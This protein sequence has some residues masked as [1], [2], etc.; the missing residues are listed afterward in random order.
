MLGVYFQDT[1]RN[2][3][4]WTASGGLENST[5][6]PSFRRFLANS[7]DSQTDGKTFAAFGQ[8]IFK[9]VEQIELAGGVR[10][11][12]ESKNSYFLQPYS[13]PIRVTQG[14]FLA[15]SKLTSNQKFSNWSPE[16]TLSWKP[17]QDINVYLAY[18][19]GYKS[20][21]FSNSGILSP[22]AGL[23]DFEF[24]PEKAEGFEAGIKTL[25]MDRQLKLNL[26]LYTYKYTNLQLDFFRSDIFA[27]TTI[28]AGS[29]TTKGIEFEFEYAPRSVPG[30]NLHGSLNYN[31]ARY[32]DAPGAPC[33]A[34]QTRTTG[35]TLVFVPATGL[36]I[37]FDAAIHTAANRQNLK[38][39]PTAN[40]PEWSGQIGMSYEADLGSAKLGF[41][42]DARYSDDYYATAFGNPFT[43]QKSYTTLDG[44]ISLKTVD[45]RWTLS[46]IGKNLTNR[47]YAT[48]GVDAPNTG[49]GT[50]SLAGTIADQVGY[51][52]NPRTVQAQITFRY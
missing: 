33:Y 6:T 23:S 47:W 41:A 15:G 34:G 26:G 2:Y 12:D 22:S 44:S 39:L 40:A 11:T 20:G 5:A 52:Q 27:F 17:M 4:A 24:E 51:V 46:L 18:K 7:K 29:A 37:P 36:S 28:N 21:G 50:G 3:M 30:L 9:P 8:L 10:Y 49:A 35:C 43:I 32:G 14:I 48:A 42:I 1:K 13:H 19:T 31:K 38:G 16:A 25:L 45:D